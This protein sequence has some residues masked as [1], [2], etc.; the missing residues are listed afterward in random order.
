[1]LRNLCF[2]TKISRSNECLS[3]CSSFS[4]ALFFSQ[5]TFSSLA[6][7]SLIY[8]CSDKIIL[9][10]KFYTDFKRRPNLSLETSNHQN[11]D[12]ICDEYDN[13]QISKIN[14]GRMRI[15]GFVWDTRRDLQVCPVILVKVVIFFLVF[16]PILPDIAGVTAFV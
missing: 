5:L 13:H 12:K 10:S 9:V 4:L 8:L 7:F 3:V 6:H 11:D 15:S 2:C 16:S 1:M 14:E